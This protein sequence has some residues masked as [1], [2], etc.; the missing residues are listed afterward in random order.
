MEVAFP[1]VYIVNQDLVANSL[2]KQLLASVNI[3][4]VVFTLPSDLLKVI[5]FGS[6]SCF[7]LSF[8]LPE[9]S[10]M[11]L[12]LTLRRQGVLSP[13]IF[14]SPQIDHELIIKAMHTGSFGFIKR[15]FQQNDFIEFIQKS[16]AYDKKVNKYAR[17][18]V[19]YKINFD[20]LSIREK[21][22]LAFILDDL[23]AMK[24]GE[25]LN[26]SHRTVENHRNNIFIKFDISK[27][28]ELIRMATIYETVR[29]TGLI[30]L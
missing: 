12:M 11:D 17:I 6:P 14:T 28:S 1:T 20:N 7:L 9:M 24:I 5:N 3:A 13:C 27:T 16:L 25:K 21:E 22:I 15:P 2:T 4:S 18:G 29:H 26:I 8:V 23:S 19:T 10:G 30:D